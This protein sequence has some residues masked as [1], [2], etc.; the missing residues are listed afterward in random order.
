MVKIF[1]PHQYMCD[2][3]NKCNPM[4][5]WSI[6]LHTQQAQLSYEIENIYKSFDTKIETIANEHI[7]IALSIKLN[8]LHYLTIYQELMLYNQFEEPQK[9]LL[10]TIADCQIKEKEIEKEIEKV[11]LPLKKLIELESDD[12]VDEYLIHDL[13]SF[14]KST[15]CTITKTNKF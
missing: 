12:D 1:N 5:M 2:E 13:N 9:L 7:E 10:E 15:G 14:I 8:E 4:N 3:A 11:K 6:D